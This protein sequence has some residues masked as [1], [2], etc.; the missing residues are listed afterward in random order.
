MLSNLL[1]WPWHGIGTEGPQPPEPPVVIT[2]IGG[3]PEWRMRRRDEL[4]REEE[5][6]LILLLI[7]E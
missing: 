6:A 3:I 4:L 1:W 7:D 5:E 2:E